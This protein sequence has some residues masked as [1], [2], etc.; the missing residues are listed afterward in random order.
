M[1]NITGEKKIFEMWM[2]RTKKKTNEEKEKW[3]TCA[4]WSINRFEGLT[5]EPRPKEEQRPQA[6]SEAR[7]QQGWL[8]IDTS[9]QWVAGSDNRAI[10]ST[11]KLDMFS[12]WNP[13]IKDC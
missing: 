9:E 4:L 11:A 5:C 2:K 12:L 13:K 1:K 8:E 7:K 6:V 10:S 3:N